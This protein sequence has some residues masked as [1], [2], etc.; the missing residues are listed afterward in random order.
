MA[1][2]VAVFRRGTVC[3]LAKASVESSEVV[4]AAAKGNIRN[5]TVPIFGKQRLRRLNPLVAQIVVKRCVGV[6][7]KQTGKMVLEKP[8]YSAACS[9]VRSSA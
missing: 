1:Q 5:G 3:V 2:F 7:L 6:L 4:K 9:S 8:I